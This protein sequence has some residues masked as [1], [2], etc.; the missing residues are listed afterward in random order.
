[1]KNISLY[2]PR[3]FNNISE[4]RIADVFEKK[5]GFGQVSKIDMVAKVNNDGK[6]THK[7]VYIHFANW[8]DNDATRA[9]QKEMENNGKVNINYDDPWFWIVLEYKKKH[10][11]TPENSPSLRGQAVVPATPKK[12]ITQKDIAR[13][14][15]K[16][17]LTNDFDAEHFGGVT[18]DLVHVSYAR[19]LEQQNAYLYSVIQ[20]RNIELHHE[21][22]NK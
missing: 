12:L 17:N 19:Y 11:S 10:V 16:R 15:A 22:N 8:N 13:G 20:Q 18:M 7:S 14:F 2:I 3:V 6:Q 4:T 9:F 21:L 5:I 1:M